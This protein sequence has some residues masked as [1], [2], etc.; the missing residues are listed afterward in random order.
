MDI[1]RFSRGLIFHKLKRGVGREK[2]QTAVP[3]EITNVLSTRNE[4]RCAT[5]IRTVRKPETAVKTTSLCV[6][7]L[8]SALFGLISPA[9]VI[10]CYSLL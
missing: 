2:A 1:W 9:L 3:G 8:V 4:K 7:Y 5:V 6:K 10:A